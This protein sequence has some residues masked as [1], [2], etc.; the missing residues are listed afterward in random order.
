MQYIITNYCNKTLLQY[1]IMQYNSIVLR[2]VSAMSGCIYVY[3]KPAKI[4]D[5]KSIV[6]MFLSA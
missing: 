5:F 4:R 1:N 6:C 3:I 2:R